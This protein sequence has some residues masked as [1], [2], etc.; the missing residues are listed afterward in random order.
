MSDSPVPNPYRAVNGVEV[1]YFYG[2]FQRGTRRVYND[3]LLIAAFRA[4]ERE[5]GGGRSAET[6]ECGHRGTATSTRR[7]VTFVTFAAFA[8]PHDADERARENPA[9]RPGSGLL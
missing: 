2:G 9:L 3:R 8:R 7:S 5:Q 1:P 4:I 6:R